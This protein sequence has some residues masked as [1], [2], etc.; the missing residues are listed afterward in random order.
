MKKIIHVD[1]SAFFRKVMKTFIAEQGYTIESFAGGEEALE[2]IKSGDIC[3]VITG[4]SL[5]DMKGEEFI[6]KTVSSQMTVPIVTV[7]SNES[8]NQLQYLRQLGVKATILK[9]DKWAERLLPYLQE[10]ALY[11]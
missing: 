7:S 2:R 10:Y 9:S 1:N 6:N 8:S 3:L 4:L 5:A 11:S